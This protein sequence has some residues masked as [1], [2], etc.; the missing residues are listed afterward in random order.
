MLAK[1]DIIVADQPTAGV[2]VGTKAQIHGLIKTQ[3]AGGTSFLVVSDDLDELLALCDRVLV[4]RHGKVVDERRGT[5]LTRQRLVD[6][7]S[8]DESTAEA[9]EARVLA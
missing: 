5:A 9:H 2:D 7:I 1:P 4:M 6:A 3:A 8:G